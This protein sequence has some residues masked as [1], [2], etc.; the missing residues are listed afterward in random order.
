MTPHMKITLFFDCEFYVHA[1]VEALAMP[2]VFP[3]FFV[4]DFRLNGPERRSSADVALM[5]LRVLNF[6]ETFDEEL[7]KVLRRNLQLGQI[8]I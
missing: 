8:N 3:Q 5:R 6:C 4:L 2:G 7:R 1:F